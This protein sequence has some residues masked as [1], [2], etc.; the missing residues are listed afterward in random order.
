V[1]KADAYNIS[2][3][4]PR[5]P[6]LV[7]PVNFASNLKT[8][9][10]QINGATVPEISR[11]LNA[12]AIP[13]PHETNARYYAQTDWNLTAHWYWHQTLRGC[14]V[15]RGDVTLAMTVT[16]PILSALNAAPDVQNRWG[17][18]IDNTIVHES[19]HAKLDLDGAREYQRALGN[20]PPAATC[21]SLQAGLRELFDSSFAAMD[22]ANVDYDRQ[23]QHGRKQGAV[24]P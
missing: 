16:V 19:G 1:L 10:Y 13:D 18:F 4:T 2:V 5:A 11:A 12:N 8:I 24:F 20:Y 22:R 17:T 15:E 14:E 7:Y 21:D 9:L 3:P 6:T 23:T